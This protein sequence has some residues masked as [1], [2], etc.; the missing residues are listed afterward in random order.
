MGRPEFVATHLEGG[1]S[2]G[3]ICFHGKD[4]VHASGFSFCDCREVAQIA[5]PLLGQEV[6]DTVTKHTQL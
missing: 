5:V 6:G 2:T 1:T 3:K 4:L